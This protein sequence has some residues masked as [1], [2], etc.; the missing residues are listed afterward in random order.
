MA[1]P[2]RIL[3]ELNTLQLRHPQ[4]DLWAELLEQVRKDIGLEPPFKKDG[5]NLVNWL[6]DA[7]EEEI[8]PE[9]R[10]GE[11]LYRVDLPEASLAARPQEL[12]IRIIEREGQ[13]VIFRAQYSGRL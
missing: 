3:N 6:A 8:I 5:D 10:L 4:A 12:A 1:G 9:G 2:S 7:L 13:K 11:V